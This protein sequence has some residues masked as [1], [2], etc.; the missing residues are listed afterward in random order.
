MFKIRSY[1]LL[2]LL[3]IVMVSSVNAKQDADC[4]PKNIKLWVE[5]SFA[6]SGDTIIIQN[7]KFKLIGV[8]APQKERKQKFNTTGQPLAKKSQDRLNK[9]LANHDLQ[10][11]V[12]YDQTEI[13]SFNRGLVHLYV[14]KK[15]KIFSLN[16][17]MLS[18]G[19]ALAKSED[20][21]NLHQACYY[22]AEQ[23]ARKQNIALWS[24]LKKQP[25]LNYP[26]VFSSK[27]RLE[28]DG[29]R[30]FKGKIISVQ[31]SSSNYILN[32][33]TTG[34]RVRKKYWNNFDY[35]QLKELK[36]KEIEVRGF[37]FLYK[38]AMYV[39]IQSP[40]AIDKLREK[41]VRTAK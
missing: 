6:S 37:G 23:Q 29:Y 30:I 11:G 38:K 27:I 13:D 1:V 10:V 5:A 14:K 9:L 2:F 26:I 40:N 33:D 34:I 36:N 8:N 7:K 16:A 22:K 21:N 18:T 31:K 12:E 41:N 28:D 4:K 3:G 20:N 17:L 32:M 24:L 39:K 15:D 25:E 35:K 19:Y